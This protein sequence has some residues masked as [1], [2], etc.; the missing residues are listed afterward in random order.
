M[1][2]RELFRGLSLNIEVFQSSCDPL[3]LRFVLVIATYFL[4]FLSFHLL[5]A[6]H[7]RQ[8][9]LSCH[10]YLKL[11]RPCPASMLRYL[12]YLEYY[13]YAS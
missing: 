10:D 9:Q 2:A 1:P 6:Y 4:A 8:L 5:F 12:R 7:Q 13:S 3:R 11:H